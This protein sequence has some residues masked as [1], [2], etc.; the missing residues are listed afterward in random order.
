MC[1]S[2]IAPLHEQVYTVHFK[3]R[4]G[5]RGHWQ[6]KAHWDSGLMLQRFPGWLEHSRKL[7]ER[8]KRGA[9][10]NLLIML[11]NYLHTFSAHMEVWPRICWRQC[12]H[13]LD[14]FRIITAQLKHGPILS[15]RAAKACHVYSKYTVD[16]LKASR[17]EKC[18]QEMK[19]KRWLGC[20]PAVRVALSQQASLRA[21]GGQPWNNAHWIQ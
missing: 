15:K 6:P 7:T 9:G 21:S 19:G 11:S 3:G 10:A 13:N 17:F 8:E 4:A 16:L 20:K 14:S 1:C 18:Q 2:S 12:V 5:R